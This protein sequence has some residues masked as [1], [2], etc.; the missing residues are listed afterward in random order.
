MRVE[1]VP[2]Q[3]ALNLHREILASERS[4]G[5][6]RRS[7]PASAANLSAFFHKHYGAG[8]RQI[9]ANATTVLE[10]VL[11]HLEGARGFLLHPEGVA[12]VP[13]KIANTSLEVG[14][15]YRIVCAA[16]HFLIIDRDA[17]E[18]LK[19]N[20]LDDPVYDIADAFGFEP[21]RDEL[22]H[23]SLNAHARWERERKSKL[24]MAAMAAGVPVEK[25]ELFDAA[26]RTEASS[27]KIA[28]RLLSLYLKVHDE[29]QQ[30]E[31]GQLVDHLVEAA[32]AAIAQEQLKGGTELIKKGP[33]R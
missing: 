33:G 10:G 8:I 24:E 19:S 29:E 25:A 18:R 28:A 9:D 14:E 12:E 27:K 4:E 3:R 6:P 20:W 13:A 26:K 32:K 2:K 15:R 21:Y 5:M 11:V 22:R 17:V 23:F 16:R 7:S 1:A 31:I 30:A